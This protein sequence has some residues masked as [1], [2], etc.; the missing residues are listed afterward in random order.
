VTTTV[1]ARG[2]WEQSISRLIE[3]AQASDDPSTRAECLQ[4]AARIYE[5]EL[6][7]AGKAL[8]VWQ[9][10]FA[11]DCRDEQAALALERLA[12]LCGTGAMVT[13]DLLPLIT[14]TTEPGARASLLGWL[15]RWLARFTGDR[16]SGEVY[17]IEALR[18]DPR[19]AVAIS[20]L[21]ELAAEQ[22]DQ[23]DATPPPRPG[24]DP[25]H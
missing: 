9:A 3:E 12:A 25:S 20:T 22:D 8:E 23:G 5:A 7:D 21:R 2:E 6:G 11:Q 1:R 19:S 18:L 15:G 14:E 10:A 24:S 17:L 16:A 13:Y 4:Q